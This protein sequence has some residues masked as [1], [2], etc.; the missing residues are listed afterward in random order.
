MIKKTIFF[1]CLAL[2]YFSS[3]A[4]L[5]NPEPKLF[6][7]SVLVE[8][9]SSEGCSSCPFADE[10]LKEVVN[11]SDSNKMPVYV[12]D[13][14][15]VIWNRSGWVDPFSDS[16]YSLRQQEYMYKK[17]LNALYTPMV[18][19]NGSDK[20][21]AGAD[22]RGIGTIISNTLSQGS[23]NFLR[24]GV[25]AVENEDSLMVAYQYWG[26]YDSCEIRVALVQKEINS[27]VKGGENS[28]LILHHH[29]VVRDFTTHPINNKEGMFKI[30][31]NHELNLENYRLVVFVQDKNT[32]RIRAVDQLTFA[33]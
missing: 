19:V 32:W 27:Q 10:F 25:T 31:M 9:F 21:Y 28:G 5:S 6:Q 29:N 13:Y 11:I 14:H 23:P 16:A 4:Q 18:F 30:Y 8:L 22:K 26:D 24:S 7:P 1:F 20:D 2:G 12:I 33:P 3:S 17:K 15:V